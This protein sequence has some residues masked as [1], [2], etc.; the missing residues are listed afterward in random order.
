M[1]KLYKGQINKVKE[2]I[3]KEKVSTSNPDGLATIAV[4]SMNYGAGDALAGVMLD[5]V[6]EKNSESLKNFIEKTTGVRP[7]FI[8]TMSFFDVF[9]KLGE[10]YLVF[11]GIDRASL[12]GR[13][14]EEMKM[15][16]EGLSQKEGD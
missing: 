10:K 6:I 11:R 1:S 4:L 15:V 2:L 9:E 3:I 16:E 13:F 8:S 7:N 12:S 14:W 5:S